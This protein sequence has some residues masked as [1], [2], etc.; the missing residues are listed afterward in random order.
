[1]TTET[2]ATEAT[3]NDLPASALPEGVTADEYRA[4]LNKTEATA[5]TGKPERPAH[6][7]EK[8]W[9]AEKG[10]IRIDDLAKSYGELEQKLTSAKKD[11][12]KPLDLKI[13]KPEGEAEAE[14]NPITTAFE[15]FA[16][17]YAETKGAPPEEAIAEIVK[18]GV[19]Q[20]IV[21]TY[22]DGLA[23]LGREQSASVIAAAGDEQ[24]LDAALAWGQNSLSK[25]DLTAYNALVENP[26]TQ[27][28][29]VEW[30]VGRFKS[31]QPQ[32]GNFVQGLSGAAVG[33][34]FSTRAEMITA[35]KSDK[36]LTDSAYQREVAEKAE[37]S[38]ANW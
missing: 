11:E 2:T 36:Y 7:A 20:G 29:G 24:T 38:I 25:E 19:P 17:T 6:I 12:E 21:Q 9:D 18:L 5:E 30:L 37:R 34:V 15:A 33:D 8:F 28:Q 14:A 1:M 13:E 26:A 16:Q 35:M 27:R 10:E 22:M 3:A 4:S 31:A 32:E 23:A